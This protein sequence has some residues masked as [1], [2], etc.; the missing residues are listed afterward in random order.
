MPIITNAQA[1]VL[2]QDSTIDDTLLNM[3]IP[4]IE[5]AI[6]EYC[7]QDFIE[8]Y[9]A[10][11]GIMPVC[12][13]YSSTIY[14]TNSDNS[15]NDDTDD[16]TETNFKANDIIRIYNSLHN[17]KMYTISSVAAHKIIIDSL[18][19]VSDEEAGNTIVFGRVGFPDNFKIV[20]S[21]MLKFALQ[22]QGVVFK[23]EKIDDYSYTRDSKLVNGYPAEIMAGL[24]SKRSLYKKQIPYNILYYRQR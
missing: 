21:Q 3:L 19:T 17:D 4:I 8:E 24:N 20:A 5:N 7:N 1:K 14:F 13:M 16:F 11:N 10:T 6:V 2:L 23:S 22:K 15:M 9:N 18:Y 12:Y